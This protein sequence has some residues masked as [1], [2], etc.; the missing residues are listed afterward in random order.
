MKKQ[1]VNTVISLGLKKILKFMPPSLPVKIYKTLS[2]FPPFK[3]ILDKIILSII[4]SQIN[5]PEGII[6]L[7]QSD[8]VVSGSL[9]LGAFENTEIELF[10]QSIKKGSTVADIGANIGYYSVIAGKCVGP[11]G[12]VFS[13][14]PEKRNFDL[15]SKN[16][17]INQLS[18]VTPIM[19][20]LSNKEGV[21]RLYL[22]EN[23]KGH[24][25]LV[26]DK[27]KKYTVIE[28]DTLDNSLKKYGSPKIDIIKMDVE[29]AEFLALEG[30]KETIERNPDVILFTEFLP[31]A[32]KSLGGEP[33]AFLKKL[34][35]M[36]F[37]L[38]LID[39]DSKRLEPIIDIE[40]FVRN[41]PKGESFHH[42]YAIKKAN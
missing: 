15:L 18:N 16:I 27:D 11:I 33:L 41:F 23:N 8:V 1:Q 31:K 5:I 28:T 26:Y 12:K 32:I 7:D 38:S 42:I 29:G 13:Y 30:M 3:I 10:R 19:C 34:I 22:D 35:S 2:I 21:S 39:E 17:Q 25:S 14:E 37:G 4:P 40:K 9:A 20:A 24:H 6:E 36:N